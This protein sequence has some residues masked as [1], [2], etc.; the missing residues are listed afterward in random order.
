MIYEAP[1]MLKTHCK[2]EDWLKRTLKTNG[3]QNAL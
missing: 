3:D 1:L 2:N